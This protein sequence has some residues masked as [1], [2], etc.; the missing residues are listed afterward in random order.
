MLLRL[1]VLVLA[2]GC[3]ACGRL[4]FEPLSSDGGR[5]DGRTDGGAPPDELAHVCGYDRVTVILDEDAT[6][7]RAGRAL[8]AAIASGCGTSP[9][10]R[11]LDEG[12][13][14]L[15]DPTSFAPLLGPNDLGVFGGDSF[16]QNVM[17]YLSMSLSPLYTFDDGVQY[18]ILRRGT[19]APVIDVAV[20]TLSATHDYAV[21]QIIHDPATDSTLVTTHG[22]Y[23]GGT[24][25]GAHYFATEIADTLTTE[26]RGFFVIEWTNV[27]G[28][29]E[30]SDGDTFTLVANG[31]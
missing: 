18:R 6:D 10:V 30:P 2:L 21:I 31:P 26:T 13:P 19:G 4:G 12:T 27:D 20:A 17:Q 5:P 9:D 22:Y 11:E 16:Y 3:P 25:A 1:L 29:P 24:L 7:N 8:A 23:F 15:L 28:D 14:G